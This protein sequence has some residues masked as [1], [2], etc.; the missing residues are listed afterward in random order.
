M[1]IN[2]HNRKIIHFSNLHTENWSESKV[3]H[4]L[5]EQSIIFTNFVMQ[6]FYLK[7][8]KKYYLKINYVQNLN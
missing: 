4:K 3:V 5:I 8:C 6:K 2:I 1:L 7:F